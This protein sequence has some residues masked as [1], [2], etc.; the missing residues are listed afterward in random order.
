MR[1]QGIGRGSFC[2][3]QR[4][5]QAIVTPLLT[6][7]A[8]TFKKS[9]VIKFD[10]Q[11]WYFQFPDSGPGHDAHVAQ[12][13]PTKVEIR[14]T[15][16]LAV[17]MEAHQRLPKEMEAD[18]CRAL[19]LNVVNADAV[20]GTISIEVLLRD[21]S[22]KP[23]AS[24]S[25]GSKVLT[26]STVS[27]MPLKRAPVHETLTFQIPRGERQAFNE[28]TVKVKPEMGRRLAAPEVAVE[29]FAFQR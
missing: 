25:L 5:R 28:I 26:S 23:V 9:D 15:N 6:A 7:T 11:Y 20:P 21:S 12:G 27:P 22:R 18:C 8:G 3:G 1:R 19:Q 29:S 13:D 17:M 2:C 10:G 16:R 24:V 14:S 4:L